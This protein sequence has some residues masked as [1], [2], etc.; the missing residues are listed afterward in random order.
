MQRVPARLARDRL[1]DVRVDLR[2]RMVAR[3][4]AERVW[5]ARIDARVVQRVAGLVHERLIV[6]DAALR[7]RD[8]VH[9]VGRIR[10]DH[11]GARILL[12]P[13]LEIELD[14]RDRG[15]VEA[16]RLHARHAHVDRAL[17]RVRR[18][19]RRQT[20]EIV[21]VRVRRQRVALRDRAACRT[22]V[23][24][25]RPYASVVVSEAA[26]STRSSS[27]QRDRLLLLVARDG[28]AARRRARA[29]SCSRGR[30]QREAVGVE[31]DDS[32]R[33]SSPSASRSA[34]ASSTARRACAERS[35]I[36]SPSKVTRAPRIAF[37][38]ASSCS[39]S[40][41]E[42]TPPSHVLRRR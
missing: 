28:I 35:G 6:G 41:A 37:S 19:E 27:A 33:S 23:S 15:H 22:S 17:L 24:R 16:E 2:Q 39:A 7:A 1:E 8:Q 9:D 11:A 26:T 29:S 14:V 4:R 40:S 42:T 36:S 31:R 30:H 18:L 10:G 5:Q 13:V 3:D 12:R 21:H 38:S 34:Y 20:A 32:A 25:R